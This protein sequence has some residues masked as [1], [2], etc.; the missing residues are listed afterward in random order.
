MSD[1]AIKFN[2]RR[3][4]EGDYRTVNNPKSNSPAPSKPFKDLMDKDTGE[5]SSLGKR[6]LANS[7]EAEEEFI[8]MVEED[9]PTPSI[10]EIGSK[11]AKAKAL[12]DA[13][14]APAPFSMKGDETVAENQPPP[15]PA[16]L[17]QNMSKNDVQSSQA[18]LH[19]HVSNETANLEGKI[20]PANKE[21][22]LNP[23][24]D[25][26]NI[27]V[28]DQPIDQPI[29][30]PAWKNKEKE[31]FASPF[32]AKEQPDLSYVNPL[33]QQAGPIE[34]VIESSPQKPVMPTLTAQQIV[35][36][37]THHM[38][39]QEFKAQGI[40]NTTISLNYPN[41]FKDAQVIVTSFDTAK[42]EFNITFQNLGTQAK[43]LLDQ[44]ATQDSLKHA[45]EVKGYMVHIIT[46]T[47]TIDQPIITDARDQYRGA[48]EDGR[49]QQQDKGGKEEE[50][51]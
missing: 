26:D 5:G 33:N 49:G 14:A 51:A 24:D 18:A 29:D 21:N 17:Y 45:L 38:E 31:K 4:G 23:F 9:N 12:K 8:S 22:K 48:R 11:Q 6:R 27:L 25:K 40:T 30:Q 28:K 34:R 35:E 46:A 3:D 19:S 20:L 39:V 44:Q 42:N 16:S 13:A 36:Q 15:S 7:K 41:M 2:P 43:T 50:E 1:S 37:I 47:T 32:A 10:F